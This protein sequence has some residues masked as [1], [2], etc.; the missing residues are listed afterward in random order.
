[1][2]VD[3]IF[4]TMNSP[5]K[6][7]LATFWDYFFTFCNFLHFPLNEE[8]QD[9]FY[10]GILR[11][12]KWFDEDVLD[13]NPIFDVE[14]LAFFGLATLLITVCTIFAN[15]LNLFGHIHNTSKFIYVANKLQG[16]SLA[17]LSSL[18]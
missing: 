3:S 8:F 18:V 10:E 1:L 15:F 9:R 14:V 12:Q 16:L 11:F 2:K 4:V 13:F 7:Q 5:A 17:S 6:W